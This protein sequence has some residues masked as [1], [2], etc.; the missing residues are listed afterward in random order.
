VA[1]A[2]KESS[3]TYVQAQSE[4]DGPGKS[5][6]SSAFVLR[7]SLAAQRPLIVQCEVGRQDAAQRRRDAVTANTRIGIIA[8]AAIQARAND[9][10]P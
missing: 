4:G 9:S 3:Q 5:F 2:A 6:R 7:K 1:E 10:A 8:L